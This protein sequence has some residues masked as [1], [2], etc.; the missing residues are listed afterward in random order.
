MGRGEA[1]GVGP[2]SRPPF[3]RPSVLVGSGLPAG[4]GVARAGAVAVG[5]EVVAVGAMVAVAVGSAVAVAVGLRVGDGLAGRAVGVGT[6]EDVVAGSAAV[7]VSGS[8]MSPVAR[9]VASSR[10]SPRA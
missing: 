6:G 3:G 4:L 8:K 10:T 9:G 1:G 2:L 5:R 7:G